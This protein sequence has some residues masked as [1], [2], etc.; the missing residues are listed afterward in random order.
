MTLQIGSDL[1]QLQQLSPIERARL[2]PCRVQQRRRVTLG[3]NEA[4]AARVLRVLR[5]ET[6]FSE[7]QRRDEVRRRAAARRMPA[8]RFG[9]G[10]ERV[11]SKAG[12]D[13]FQGG[14]ER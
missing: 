7:E 5:V 3:E 4:I 9:S 11:D 1:T 6:H 14:N 10:M 12:R 8:A 13:I 2:G